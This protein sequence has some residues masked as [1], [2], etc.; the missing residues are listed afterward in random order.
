MQTVEG[1]RL[2]RHNV[3]FLVT[4]MAKLCAELQ[5]DLVSLDESVLRDF[6]PALG[7]Y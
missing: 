5:G 3:A 7:E 1:K 2:A 4:Y 6:T